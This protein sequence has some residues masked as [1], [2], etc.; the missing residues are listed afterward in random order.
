M[1]DLLNESLSLRV[2]QTLLHFVWQGAA[3]A[4]AVVIAGRA[5]QRHSAQLRYVIN[6]SAMVLMAA[7]LPVTFAVVSTPAQLSRLSEPT[8]SSVSDSDRNGHETGNREPERATR[9]SKAA[10][11]PMP[12]AKVAAATVEPEVTASAQ[13]PVNEVESSGASTGAGNRF[14]DWLSPISSGLTVI[15]LIGVTVMLLRLAFGLGG[16]MRL[17]GGVI[18]IPDG[19]LQE[20]I[21]RQARLI[22]LKCVPA[23]GLCRKISVPIVSGILKPVILLPATVTTGLSSDQ[24]QALLLH[25]LAHIRRFDLF[26]NLLQ[27]L[28]ES[29]LFFHPA[30]WFVSRRVAIAREE[31]ADDMVLAAGMPRVTYADALVRMAEL[32]ATIRTAPDHATILAANGASS[33]DLKRRVLRLLAEPNAPRLSMSR[34]G[35]LAVTVAAAALLAVPFAVHALGSVGFQ[36]AHSDPLATNPPADANSASEPADSTSAVLKRKTLAAPSATSWA[37]FR[38]GHPQRGV[39]GCKLPDK[40][41]L[42]WKKKTEHGVVATSAIVGDHVYVPTLEGILFCYQRRTGREIWSYRTTAD[43]ADFAPGLVSA[44]TVTAEAVFVGDEDGVLHVIDRRNGEKLWLFKTGAQISGGAQIVRDKVIF[45]SH[46]GFLYC[47]DRKTGDL[48]W[49][50]KTEDRINSVP[51][52]VKSLAFIAGCDEYIRQINIET[53]RQS[54]AFDLETYI[55]ASPAA[56]GNYLYVGGYNGEFFSYNWK[57][58]KVAWKFG[59]RRSGLEFRSSAAITDELVVVGASDRKLHCLDRKTGKEKW[60]YATRG[61]IQSSPAIVGGRVIFGSEDRNIFCLE[62]STGK[63]L[64]KFNAG[65][66]VTAG[67]AVGESVMVVGSAGPGGYIYCF[68]K[69]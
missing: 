10:G 30:V 51:A 53:R 37:S 50:V 59:D 16:A 58:K 12:A 35:I 43:A 3:I 25:E 68:G 18:P 48:K 6:V 21:R 49:K 31:A 41:E 27:R 52:I 67:P 17:R 57:T 29:V 40:L 42:L 38:N 7:C 20:M 4:A 19:E 22:G 14:R 15:Y 56:M 23:I 2:A 60:A 9:D 34:S 46:D 36:L 24:L 13:S 69:K 64:W 61:Q 39:A 66:S 65:N 1:F 26:I 54:S 8:R 47:L 45:G 28:V 63:L 11:K 55:I 5:L 44:P 62:L 33:S 32:S